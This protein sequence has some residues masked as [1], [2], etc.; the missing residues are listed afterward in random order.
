MSLQ[1]GVILAYIV[2]QLV[3][4]WFVSRRIRGEDDYLVAGR[5]LGY[6]LCTFTIFATWFG[7]ESLI[8]GAGSVYADGLAGGSADPFG[9]AICLLLLGALFAKP[10]WDRKLTTFGDLFR[11]RYGLQTER[12]AAVLL[13][14]T[15]VLWAAAQIRGFGQVLAANSEFHTSVAIAFAAAIVITYTAFGGLKA[16]AVTDLIQG[17]TLIAGILG[18]SWIVFFGDAAFDWSAVPA[19]RLSLFPAERSWPATA[20]AWAVPVFGSLFAAEVIARVAAARNARVARTGLLAGGTAFLVFGTLA[21]LI[22]VAGATE[23]PGLDD[24]EQVIIAM[25]DQRLGPTLRILFSGALA[26]AILSTVD[27]VLLTAGSLLAHNLIIPMRPAMSAR[28][29]LRLNRAG[30]VFFGVVSYW[31]AVGADTVWGLVEESSALGS[32]GV[33]VIVPFAL[34]SRFGGASAAISS[35]AAGGVS[36]IVGA[37]FW[38]WECPYL[39][40]ICFALAG[41]VLPAWLA[42]ESPAEARA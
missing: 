12:V 11:Q 36:Y 6:G 26:A 40:S 22:G 4:A 41:Y 27:S 29:R 3:V 28:A 39:I 13:I 25:A 7:A 31:V 15:S 10:L 19:E 2:V 5:S 16:D 42:K 1:L 38:E 14:P 20:E 23:L 21:A 24:P 34:F 18:L 9:Y 30:V 32:S 35:L 37:Y 17:I 8:S 33:F